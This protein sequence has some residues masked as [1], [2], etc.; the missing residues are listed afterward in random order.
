MNQ[1]KRL[2]TM[3]T[4]LMVVAVYVSA[5]DD[6]D[7]HNKAVQWYADR[8]NGV[9]LRFEGLRSNT[10][11]LPQQY[12]VFSYAQ[13]KPLGYA[14]VVSTSDESEMVMFTPDGDGIKA[15]SVNKDVLP[16]ENLYWESITYLGRNCTYSTDITL[17]DRP[18]PVRTLSKSKNS[19]EV[20]IED[21]EI[22]PNIKAYNQMIFKPHK[23]AVRLA[24]QNVVRETDDDGNITE[25]RQ[26]YEFKLTTPSVV[27]KMFRG[28]QDNEASPW[29]VKSNFFDNHTLLQYSRWKE[30]E[31]VKKASKDV[32]RA[33]TDYYQGWRIKDT[34]WL[35]TTESGD[36]SFYAVQFEIKGTRALAAMV[37][38]EYGEVVST[39]EFLGKVEPGASDGYQSIWFVDDEGDFMEHAPEI[40][41]I[42]ATDEGME[43]YVRQY[44]GESVQYSILREMGTVWMTM[45]TDYWIYVWE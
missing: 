2:L 40:H 21:D 13:A 16:K 6:W 30:G 28:Y 26:E 14:M 38:L 10:G 36:R 44:G 15:Q 29:V 31:P 24:S 9:I 4:M 33:I 19:F 5:Q 32:C 20:V 1:I 27:N 25:K 12:C 23:N 45:L 43:L 18:L 11:I 35:A 42:V 39:W 3:M 37:C 34:R 8:S 7:A 22:I 41:C 17:K